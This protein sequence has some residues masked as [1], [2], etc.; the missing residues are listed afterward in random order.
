LKERWLDGDGFRLYY[1][2]HSLYRGSISTPFRDR[3]ALEWEGVEPP[4]S[5]D[6]SGLTP[7]TKHLDVVDFVF[8]DVGLSVFK[9]PEDQGRLVSDY[10][11]SEVI[12]DSDIEKRLKHS[13]RKN[14][15]KAQEEY[16]LTLEINPKDECEN[17]YRIYLVNR[18][19]LGVL[20]YPCYFFRA[21]FDLSDKTLIVFACRSPE[22]ILGYLICYLHGNEMISGHM[23]YD[24]EQRHKRISD[25]LFISAFIWGRE[26][27][28]TSY[29]FGA[30]NLNQISLIES[31]QKLGA[32]IRPQWDFRMRPKQI[33][34]DRPTSPVRRLLRVAPMTLYRH[35]GI[36][37]KLYFA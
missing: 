31:K 6:L 19:K 1:W 18:K 12:L 28:F 7:L 36:L 27:G 4:K 14:F 10:V 34:K 29:R 11:N 23:A 17:F 30:D 33:S 8:K 24:F 37:T 9:L 21:L 16:R 3:L 5:F 13:A 26:N 15:R 2:T 22:G 32:I 35:S 25:F 20:P